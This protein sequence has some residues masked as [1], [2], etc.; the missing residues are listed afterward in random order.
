MQGSKAS[1]TNYGA[2]DKHMAGM[3]GSSN[4]GSK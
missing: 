4:N 2:I 1:A 3:F